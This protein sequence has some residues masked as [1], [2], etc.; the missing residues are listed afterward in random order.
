MG[1]L[2]CHARY[3]E[4]GDSTLTRNLIVHATGTCRDLQVTS[5]GETFNRVRESI[6]SVERME[7]LYSRNG[8]EVLAAA[9][10]V[11]EEDMHVGNCVSLMWQYSKSNEQHPEF[12]R[13]VFKYLKETAKMYGYP[14]AYS[15]RLSGDT[16]VIKYKYK[17]L[18]DKE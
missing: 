13:Y 5:K 7:L 10:L 2:R 12:L 8:H 15:K 3:C 11:I 4:A 16:Y 6:E 17:H 9:I 1:T 14:Y 18:I